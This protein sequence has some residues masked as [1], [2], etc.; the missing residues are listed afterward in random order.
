MFISKII[1]FDRKL[2]RKS[3]NGIGA[4]AVRLL[5][6][7][8]DSGEVGAHLMAFF[9]SRNTCREKSDEKKF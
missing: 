3:E 7:I 6:G 8:A 2:A 9:H 5:S 4:V 1:I